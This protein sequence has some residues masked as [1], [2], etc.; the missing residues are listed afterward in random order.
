MSDD[1]LN[2]Y[3]PTDESSIHEPDPIVADDT[4]P[5]IWPS[6]VAP[7]AAV[8]VAVG[9]QVIMAA[10]LA[11]MLLSSGVETKELPVQIIERMTTP[12]LF[13]LTLVLGQAAFAAVT[14]M[15]G[16]LSPEPTMQRLGYLG[17][18][19]PI[20]LYLLTMAGSILV[21]ALAIGLVY[22]VAIF[23][24]PDKSVEK[25]FENMT[26][27]WGI[28]FVVLIAFLPG[29]IEETMF[30]G[31]IQTRLLK[32]WKP[33]LAIGVSSTLFALVHITPHAIAVAFPLGVWFGYIAWKTNSIGPGIACHA[34]VNGGLNVWRLVVKFGELS[35]TV[36]Y[37]CNGIF[38]LF[39]VVCFLLAMK[40]LA[41]YT[42]R[43]Q[44]TNESK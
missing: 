17:A 19:V 35:E 14:L 12:G 6:F 27:L 10:V 21:L 29:F 2:P 5:R 15:A 39:G 25:L 36:Q 34:F 32:R 37:V 7:F 41:T 44:T 33:A 23:I 38:L 3:S 16:R 9:L 26:P 1:Q 11:G 24:P 30:R 13:L 8:L 22:L 40:M 20:K 4:S 43:V 18:R 28:A 42:P 31:Y